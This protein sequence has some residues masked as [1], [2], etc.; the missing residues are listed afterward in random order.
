MHRGVA[1]LLGLVLLGFAPAARAIPF[2]ATLGFTLEGAYSP[3]DFRWFE[4]AA[5]ADAEGSL[6]VDG[7]WQYP[8]LGR[9]LYGPSFYVYLA[10]FGGKA[11]GSFGGTLA[12]AKGPG[13]G[14]GGSVPLHRIGTAGAIVPTHPYT[15]SVCF[16][17]AR[18]GR[19]KS[20]F[21]CG[22]AGTLVSVTGWTTGNVTLTG[23]G[24]A[25]LKAEGYD[26]RTPGGRGN[27]LL[28]T[29]IRI[30]GGLHPSPLV[31]FGTLSLALVPEPGTLALT[32]SGAL[33]LAALGRQ[34][35][36]HRRA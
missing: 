7:T 23:M 29:P 22:P 5:V 11:P 30:D 27:L 34:R 20:Q 21:A 10:I 25:M 15:S 31:G 3:I 36:R 14:L 28:V 6:R 9:V 13:G 19:S 24:G 32:A 2:S 4:G 18:V 8:F 16:G 35:A 12:P 26:A 17:L 33:A 1:A